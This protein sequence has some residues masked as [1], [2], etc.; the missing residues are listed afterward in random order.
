[1]DNI[2][3]HILELSEDDEHDRL[4]FPSYPGTVFQLIYTTG[5]LIKRD[6]VT[7]FSISGGLP[8]F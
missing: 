4:T 8:V 2:K 1:M 5:S 7:R 6:P 3:C